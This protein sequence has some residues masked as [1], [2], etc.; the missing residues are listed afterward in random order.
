MGIIEN[1]P[2]IITFIFLFTVL[3]YYFLIFVKKKIPPQEHKFSS[4]TIIIPAHN[5]EMYIA[6]AIESVLEANFDGKK[7]TKSQSMN[8]KTA[9]PMGAAKNNSG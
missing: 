6:E 8:I 9:K 5:E 2:T 7:Q 1:L 3:S 4:I